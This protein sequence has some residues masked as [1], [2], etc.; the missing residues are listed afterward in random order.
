MSF[1]WWWA[2]RFFSKTFEL[3]IPW[4]NVSIVCLLQSLEDFGDDDDED[5]DERGYDEDNEDD[6]DEDDRKPV[7]KKESGKNT[8]QNKECNIVENYVEIWKCETSYHWLSAHVCMWLNAERFHWLSR[9]YNLHIKTCKPH[10]RS[11]F[12]NFLTL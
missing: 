10:L 8:R 3:F 7:E 2:C 12:L 1:C 6:Q 4:S 11:R 5:M 9:H